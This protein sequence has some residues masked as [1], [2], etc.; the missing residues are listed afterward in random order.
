V[1]MVWPTLL[2]IIY[3][4]T[5]TRIIFFMEYRWNTNQRAYCGTDC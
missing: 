2:N 3:S 5:K 1:I 4:G